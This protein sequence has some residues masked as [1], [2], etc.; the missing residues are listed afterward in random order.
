M[1]MSRS[2]RTGAD[3]PLRHFAYPRWLRTL[4]PAGRP[5]VHTTEASATAGQRAPAHGD[6]W[7]GTSFS[8]DP[9]RKFRQ[10]R[11]RFRHRKEMPSA[12]TDETH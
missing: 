10:V 1:R 7:I 3:A 2:R 4:L 12:G 6:D 9:D 8:Y 11:T 5:G